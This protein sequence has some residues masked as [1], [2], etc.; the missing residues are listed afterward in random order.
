MLRVISALLAGLLLCA[1]TPMLPGFPPGTFQNRAALDATGGAPAY[2]G[3]G[4]TST[5]FAW[6][7]LR[8]YSAAKRGNAAI[9]VCNVL[10]VACA[11]MSTDAVTGAL[12]VTIIGG[13]NCSVVV[14][15]VK[16]LYDQTQANNCGGSTCDWT[17]ATIG[18]RPTLV[19]SCI[20]S[21]PCMRF[22]AAS[23][24]KL[25]MANAV[26]SIQSQPNT[27]TAVAKLTG[28]VAF[29]PIMGIDGD[30]SII[31]GHT[32]NANQWRIYAG[33]Q[34]AV[35][36]SDASFHVF[37]GLLN[38]TSSN[39]NIDGSNNTGDT[40]TDSI[41]AARKFLIGSDSFGSLWTGDIL[42][43]GYAHADISAG[44]SGVNSNTTTYWGPF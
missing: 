29:I 9:N 42:E 2:T 17:Q 37:Q 41:Q 7:G 22:D 18:N 35:S 33:A 28:S 21:K 13:S 30:G 44:F 3:P 5:Y 34:V 12:T 6:G 43:A 4:D 25:T 1:Q 14:C 15:T 36:V 39:F 23:S 26:G 10:D 40:G 19:V 16:T 27:L 20:N 31:M 32:N 11:D 24:Q 38:G 8:A